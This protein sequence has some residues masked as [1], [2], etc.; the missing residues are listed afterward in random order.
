MI[1]TL[2]RVLGCFALTIVLVQG[3]G[4]DEQID[5]PSIDT[6]EQS[7]GSDTS[8]DGKQQSDSSVDTSSTDAALDAEK[9]DEVLEDTQ[10]A[11]SSFLDSEG[12]ETIAAD[13]MAEDTTSTDIQDTANPPEDTA[14]PAE[15]TAVA[16]DTAVPEEDI[17]EPVEDITEVEDM[18]APVTGSCFGVCGD[19]SSAEGCGC[20]KKC[21]ETG[22][23]CPDFLDVC[24]CEVTGCPPDGVCIKVFSYSCKPVCS[25]A[26]GGCGK[27]TC[28]SNPV[29]GPIC[30]CPEN[31]TWNEALCISFQPE[32]CDS[33]K[34]NNCNGTINENCPGQT[35]QPSPIPEC[36]CDPGFVPEDD[37]CVPEAP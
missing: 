35:P 11:D 32:D 15:D 37:K 1:K 27:L 3:C 19:S 20:T 21:Q 34:D 2:S 30:V 8:A 12:T 22:T 36:V 14:S 17:E 33:P 7:Q 24:T 29:D 25:F 5:I 28:T 31:A 4:T 26:N 6:H 13:G 9:K 23:C 10:E 16:Q 18:G